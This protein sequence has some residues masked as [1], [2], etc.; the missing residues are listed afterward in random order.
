[1]T[2]W[3]KI[4]AC[5]EFGSNIST[6][7]ATILIDGCIYAAGNDGHCATFQSLRSVQA[8]FKRFSDEEYKES[9]A[10]RAEDVQPVSGCRK[11]SRIEYEPAKLIEKVTEVNSAVKTIE[12]ALKCQKL[13]I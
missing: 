1:M 2:P 3:G 7:C 5:S 10:A 6:T 13:D 9:S 4:F 8:D 11:R 12:E